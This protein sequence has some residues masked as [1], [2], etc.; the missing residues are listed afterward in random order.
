MND[1]NRISVNEV[2]ALRTVR[3]YLGHQFH[4]KSRAHYGILLC[5][6]GKIVFS[7]NGREYVSDPSHAL[8]LPKGEN[9]YLHGEKAGYFPLINFS[10]NNAF[11]SKEIMVIRLSDP[12]SYLRE[13]EMIQHLSLFPQNRAQIMSIL[14]GM[15]SRLANERDDKKDVL[16]PAIKYL[17]Q[18]YTDASLDMAVLAK[19]SHISVPYFH[20]LFRSRFETTPGQYLQDIRIRKAML[21]LASS[22]KTVTAVAEACGFSSVYHFSRAFRMIT[23][24]S[25]TEYRKKAEEL[26]I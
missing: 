3:S 19:E 15:I 7:H 5:V 13:Y 10:C 17:E 23:G 18:N 26:E 24:E 20:K 2:E 22:N 21:L 12:E 6:K 25:P 8:V 11:D 9:Y 14:Y 16:A 4:V 1:L